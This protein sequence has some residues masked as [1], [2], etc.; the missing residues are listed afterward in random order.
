MMLLAPVL[1]FLG[2]SAKLDALHRWVRESG[3]RV[4]CF[5]ESAPPVGAGERCVGCRLACVRAKS[6]V[7]TGLFFFF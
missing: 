2:R 1:D 4:G 5:G 6:R 7:G 3:A